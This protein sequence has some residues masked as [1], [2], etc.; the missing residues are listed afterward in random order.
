EESEI[1]DAVDDESL[2]SGVGVDLVVEPESNQ[3]IGAEADSLPANEQ[4][5]IV[6]AEHQH[7]HEEDKQVEV[8]EEPRV[9]WVVTHVADAEDM[10]QC[11]DTGDDE[12]HHHR[13]LI[14]LDRGIDL[15]VASRHPAEV[16]L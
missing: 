1:S 9:A 14:E 11:A 6:R 5:R 4:D 2:L 13:Q 7:Q 15:Q 8:R 3:K 16:A 12:Y 10:D